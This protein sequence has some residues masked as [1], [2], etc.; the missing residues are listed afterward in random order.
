MGWQ[1][2]HGTPR[3]NEP[4]GRR[5]HDVQELLHCAER[6]HEL[7]TIMRRVLQLP[8]KLLFRL[9]RRGH[10]ESATACP[11]Q[12]LPGTYVL[13]PVQ[14]PGPKPCTVN[15]VSQHCSLGAFQHPGWGVWSGEGTARP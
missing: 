5:G 15:K 3:G 13:D 6:V 2:S 7:G 12:R 1:R 10:V 9:Q 4:G 14:T 8:H 11:A